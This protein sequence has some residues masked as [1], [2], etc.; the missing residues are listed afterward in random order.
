MNKLISIS[1]RYPWILPLIFTMLLVLFPPSY[2]FTRICLV[3]SGFLLWISILISLR[4]KKVALAAFIGSSLLF[5][6]W[7]MLPGKPVDPAQLRDLYVRELMRYE[8]SLYV[9][10]GENRLGIDCSGLVRRGLINANFRLGIISLN[11][12]PIR[13]AVDLWWHDCTAKALKDGYRNLT[14]PL[15]NA[16]SVNS[17]THLPLNAGDLAITR[18]GIHVMAFL[19]NGTWIEADPSVLKVIRVALPT[20]NPWFNQAIQIVRWRELL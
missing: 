2:R 17:T 13:H 15:T 1:K 19:G 16:P 14:S 9:W 20:D 7:L 11:P 10:G 8:G 5:I 4:R 6:T 12:Q 18:N 3:I